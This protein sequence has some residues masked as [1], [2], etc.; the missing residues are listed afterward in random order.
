[1]NKKKFLIGLCIMQIIIMAFSFSG[2]K[3]I[4]FIEKQVNNPLKPTISTGEKVKTYYHDKIVTNKDTYLYCNENKNYEKCGKIGK[5]IELELESFDEKQNIPYFQL[6]G[7]PYFLFYQDVDKIDQMKK[8]NQNYKKYI[9]FPEKVKMKKTILYKDDHLAFELPESF[10]SSVLKV[11]DDKRYVEYNNDL[12]SIKEEDITSIE[13][14][15][16]NGSYAKAISVLNYHFF[17]EDDASCGEIICLKKS[18]FERQMKYLADEG[19]Y[20]PTMQEFEW[21]LDGKI[22]LPQKSVLI[23]VDD[24]AL[25]ADTILPEIL[26]KYN[27]HA[28]LF[29]ITGWNDKNK[30]TSSHIELHSHS[31]AMHTPGVC[32]DGQGG[33]IK[34]LPK[35]TI[36]ADLKKTRDLL[37]QTTAFAYPFYEYNQRAIDLLKEAGFT[38]AFIGSRKKAYPGINKM[39]IPRYSI[40]SSYTM[41]EFIGIVS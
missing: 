35:D 9:A 6:K 8:S 3:S 11:D 28:S 25:G 21:F 12:Y 39:L 40:V 27:L 32:P 34:C 36:L 37:N 5:N 20:T 26:E 23:T 15:E 30:F 22:R 10:E 16:D 13:K 18:M 2:V 41:N 29:L 33:G 24:G 17:Y 19:Y 7:Q 4:L 1:M 31:D 38:M 14:Q